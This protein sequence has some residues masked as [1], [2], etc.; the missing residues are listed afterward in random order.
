MHTTA[1]SERRLG[2]SGFLTALG[3]AAGIRVLAPAAA[4]ADEAPA[5]RGDAAG[6]AAAGRAGAKADAGKGGELI[7]DPLERYYFLGVRFRDVVVPQ[8]MMEIF[9]QGGGTGNAWL[10]GPE[11]SMRKNRTEIDIALAY[12]DYGFGPAMFRG[13][14][15]GDIAYEIVKSDLK[16]AYLTFDLLYDIPIG[17]SGMFSFL[18]GGGVG[19]GIVAGDLY[20]NQAYPKG[21]TPDPSDPSK[22][23]YCAAPNDPRGTFGGQVYCDDGNDAYPS[24]G[25]TE[26]SESSWADGGQKPIVLPWLSLPQVSFRVKPIKQ[27]QARVDAGFSIWGFFFGLSAGYGF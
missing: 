18:I 16:V 13:K 17:E 20:R 14:S 8:F 22:W 12:A 10:I 9:A 24:G 23:E 11:L 1:H 4:L 7:E 19:V 25:K 2:K 27:L 21:G 15:D 3:V 6:D 26:H 5:S